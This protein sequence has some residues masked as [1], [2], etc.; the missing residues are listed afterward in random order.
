MVRIVQA[1]GLQSWSGS[2]FLFP[3][4][5]CPHGGSIVGLRKYTRAF[6]ETDSGLWA[7]SSVGSKTLRNLHCC[8]GFT[9]LFTQFNVELLL[10][11]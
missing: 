10:H 1:V 7:T 5:F 8:L 3:P 9:C 2:T 4:N 6:A 11:C